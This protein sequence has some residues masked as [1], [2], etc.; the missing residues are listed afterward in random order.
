MSTYELLKEKVP[1]FKTVVEAIES[2][3]GELKSKIFC[4]CRIEAKIIPEE[5]K[6]EIQESMSVVRLPS[7]VMKQI[8]VIGSKAGEIATELSES[9]KAFVQGKLDEIKSSYS[10]AFEEKWAELEDQGVESDVKLGAEAHSAGLH[11]LRDCLKDNLDYIK[12][13]KRG[14]FDKARKAVLAEAEA[15]VEEMKDAVKESVEEQ[16]RHL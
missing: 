15:R 14:D 9:A 3:A 7:S 2:C 11:A 4:C 6:S 16:V 1:C 5:L 10:D 13:V 12:N 8:K